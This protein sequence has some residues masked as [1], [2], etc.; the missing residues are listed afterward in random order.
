[1]KIVIKLSVIFI[2]F[3]SSKELKFALKLSNKPFLLGVKNG[4][5]SFFNLPRK[6]CVEELPVST[7]NIST[8]RICVCLGPEASVQDEI[9][10]M[11]Q[12]L[13]LQSRL[14]SEPHSGASAEQRELL[15]LL[16]R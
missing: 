4:M 12:A 11:C 6:S 1:M 10:V 15:P 2:L 7:L 3:C 14:S 8:G 13:W 9:R 16:F 5:L